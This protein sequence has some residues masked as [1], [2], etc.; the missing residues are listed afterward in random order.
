[1]LGL[2]LYQGRA[3][4]LGGTV[5]DDLG[6]AVVL[7][8]D[9]S[10]RIK[11]TQDNTSLV[12]LT[13]GGPTPAGSTLT[14]T[15]RGTAASS[16][17]AATAAAWLAVVLPA[18]L[19]LARLGSCDLEV[20]IVKSGTPDLPQTIDQGTAQVFASLPGPVTR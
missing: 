2:L 7:A 8:A 4:V 17:A 11:I 12:E 19:A 15:S 13:S 16:T 9:D 20:L 6:N 14:V 5:L 1:M 18:D 10:L 3:N